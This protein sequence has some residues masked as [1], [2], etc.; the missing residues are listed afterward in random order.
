MRY[1]Y[2]EGL[3]RLLAALRQATVVASV[4]ATTEDD[5]TYT[6][7]VNPSLLQVGMTISSP[8]FP[9]G[10]TVL[11]VA[12]ATVEMS[13]PATATA[14]PANVTGVLPAGILEPVSLHALL[15]AVPQSPYN[16]FADLTPATFNGYAAKVLTPGP[17]Q[18][19]PGGLLASLIYGCITWT[20][21]NYAVP[22]TIVGVAWTIPGDPDPILLASEVL[23]APIALANPGQVLSMLPMLPLPFTVQAP[24]SPIV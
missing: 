24:P 7:D 10:T 6:D 19:V 15:D 23:E 9:A 18:A 13:N 1:Y 12:G 3:K 5:A 16:V 14:D 8:Q 11:S 4:G 17:V 21:T 2:Y 22:N 20:P